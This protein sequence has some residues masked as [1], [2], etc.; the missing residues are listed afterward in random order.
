LSLPKLPRA[1]FSPSIAKRPIVSPEAKPYSIDQKS[2]CWR[3]AMLDWG[4]PFGFDN[5]KD[6]DL[7]VL[8]NRLKNLESMK[9]GEILR[10]PRG[11]G[12]TENH[13]ISISELCADAQRRLTELKHNDLD[14]MLSVTISGKRRLWGKLVN[15]IVYV[16]WWDPEHLICPSAKKHT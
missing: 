2:P 1:G 4:G 12:G 7:R 15:E 13:L 14:E 9:W 8:H 16:V 3:F 5:M 10:A 6:D 11:S